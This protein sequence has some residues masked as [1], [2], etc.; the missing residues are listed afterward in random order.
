V[1]KHRTNLM[2]KLGVRSAAAVA[3]YAISNGY[4]QT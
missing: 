2:R 4:L 1:E 3:A